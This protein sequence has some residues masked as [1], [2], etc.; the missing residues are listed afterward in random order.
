MDKHNSNLGLENEKTTFVNVDETCEK[1]ATN[2]G[3][4][5]N[6]DHAIRIIK[7][8]EISKN[9]IEIIKNLSDIMQNSNAISVNVTFNNIGGDN[10]IDS[11]NESAGHNN[12]FNEAVNIST[13]NKRD[14]ET[15]F[16]E[17]AVN[18]NCYSKIYDYLE[19]NQHNPYCALLITLSIFEDC[20]YDLIC[21]EAKILYKIIGQGYYSKTDL[22][23]KEI[24]VNYDRFDVSRQKA[25][26]N[27]GIKFYKNTVITIG[28]KIETDFVGFTSNFHALN[29]L[30]CVF[31][32]FI[33][34]RDKVTTFLISLICSEKVVLYATSI[35]TFKKLCDINPEFFLSKVV[36][37]LLKKKIIPADIAVAQILCSIADNSNAAYSADRY[38]KFVSCV[39]KDVH[40]YVVILMM[41]KT[42]AYQREKIAKLIRPILWELISQPQ[43]QLVLNSLE[44]KLPS[45]E[46]FINNVDL[47]FNIGNRYAEYY[48]ALVSELYSI[49]SKMKHNDPRR[50]SVILVILLFIK[51][52]YNESCLNTNKIEKFADMIFIR[53]S[54]RTIICNKL[55]YL[56]N[57]ILGNKKSKS[58]AEKFL[59]NY[60]LLRNDYAVGDEYEKIKFFFIKLK[61]KENIA[62]RTLFFLKKLYTNPSNPIRLARNLYYDLGGV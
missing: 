28:G 12:V 51:E 33:E 13:A 43:L 1:S 31:S 11:V 47:F 52:D 14:N 10:Y 23:D 32:E 29:V 18:L 5:D 56:W 60:L 15:A 44:I 59:A 16:T 57:E 19:K 36:T 30:R 4:E 27:F 42:L 26:S 41:C 34:L 39:D 6:K 53:L 3:N 2:S 7:D 62:G 46:N 49:L 21:E 37:C 22:E 45:E 9:N 54:L 25:I 40:Y 55:M 8:G 17:T 58:I 24:D 48:I 20:Q 50:E 35:N 61:E 38:L